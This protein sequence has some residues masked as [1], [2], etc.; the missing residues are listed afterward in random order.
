MEN[1][2]HRGVLL[3]EDSVDVRATAALFST[4]K[5]LQTQG[6]SLVVVDT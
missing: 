5:R 1:F 4:L 3:F 2:P 6:F